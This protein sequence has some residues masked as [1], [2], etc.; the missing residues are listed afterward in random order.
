MK[1]YYRFGN[2]SLKIVAQWLKMN[3]SHNSSEL[4]L[5]HMC[6]MFHIHSFPDN[7]FAIKSWAKKKFG[8]ENTH[9]DK[10]FGIPEDFDYINWPKI[11]SLVDLVIV[12]NSPQS[13][14]ICLHQFVLHFVLSSACSRQSCKLYT[15]RRVQ[16]K[17]SAVPHPWNLNLV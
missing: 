14:F 2:A 9:L 7:V 15:L 12:F 8:F 17:F 6:V 16:C 5:C 1:N 10:A 4:F 13:S 3:S 11:P